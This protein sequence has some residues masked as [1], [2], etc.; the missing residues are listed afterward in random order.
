MSLGCLGCAI[1]ARPGS[2]SSTSIT[3]SAP[4]TSPARSTL[5]PSGGNPTEQDCR[6]TRAAYFD[7]FSGA[8]G[9]MILGALVDAGLRFE[10]LEAEIAKLHLPQGSYDL[11]ATKVT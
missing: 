1:A 10:D 9:D 11:A 2:R 6:M 4:A 7:C 3:A 5:S 8:S